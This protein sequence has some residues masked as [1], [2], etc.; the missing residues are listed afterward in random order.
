MALVESD[1]RHRSTLSDRLRA[2]GYEV[3][4]F[5][6]PSVAANWVLGSPPHALIADV[7][8]PGVS[9]VQLCRLLKA[10]PATAD[11]PIILRAEG[12]PPKARF[13]AEQ[14]G[15]AAYVPKGHIGELVRALDRA[16]TAAPDASGFFTHFGQVDIRDRIAQHLDRALFESV[17]A[18]SV[19]A[20]G[21]CESFARL[22]DLF[23]QFVCRV[24]SYRW[25]AIRV[26]NPAR[27][28]LHCNPGSSQLCVA[29]ARAALDATEDELLLVEDE[30]ALGTE[31]NATV[32]QCPIEFANRRLGTL[33]IHPLEGDEEIG[34]T[35]RLI[36]DEIGGPMRIAMLVE[37]AQRLA[38][39]DPLT[40]I[41]N[42]RAFMAQ[43]GREFDSVGAELSQFS[44]LLLDLDH[45][46]VINDTYGHRAGDRVL[47]ELG[48]LLHQMVRQRARVARWGGEEFVIALADA[49]QSDARALAEELRE[50][51]A[52]LV[53]KTD[54]GHT[55][56]LSASI[57]VA[58]RLPEEPFE[59][60]V[61]RADRAMYSAKVGGRNRVEVA[62]NVPIPVARSLRVPALTAV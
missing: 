6:D 18:S 24:A 1:E 11:V 47:S 62:S 54:D 49:G 52:D 53:V 46:K 61:E 9:G 23:S 25:L 17:L 3:E 34:Q 32:I 28:A 21:S 15:A 57:G 12:N 51:V 31:S 4:T 48:R 7:W 22:F 50:R 2:Q 13:W 60:L 19:R 16:I 38:L 55:I 37:E 8:M 36:A 5:A 10:E 26:G 29:A 14:A 27:L 30:D 40:G 41:L 44:L 45:F 56:L 43:L 35:L 33:A 39:Y 42:R 58:A 59:S 20:L